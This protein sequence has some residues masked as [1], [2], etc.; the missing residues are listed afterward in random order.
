MER[1]TKESD[2]EEYEKFENMN[3]HDSVKSSDYLYIFSFSKKLVN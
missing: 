3:N 2:S 1:I